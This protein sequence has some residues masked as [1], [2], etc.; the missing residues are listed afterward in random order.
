MF[1]MLPFRLKRWHFEK[2]GGPAQFIAK[3]VFRTA[4]DGERSRHTA[5][6]GVDARAF[7][8]M[9]FESHPS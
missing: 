8:L 7:S 6:K 2:R 4:K 3:T 1:Q 5:E 9:M